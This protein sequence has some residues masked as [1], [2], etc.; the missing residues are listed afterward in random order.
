KLDRRQE[1]TVGENL[2]VLARSAH[3]Y[4]ALDVRVIGRELLIA[5]RPVLLDAFQAALAEVALGEAEAGG[6]PV[7][8]ASAHGPDAVD[9]DVVAVLVADRGHDFGRIKRL[10]RLVPLR[11]VVRPGMEVEVFG[12][13]LSSGFHQGHFGASLRQ[14]F[15][16]HAARGSRAD[17]ANIEQFCA[18]TSQK[19]TT[20]GIARFERMCRTLN[21]AAYMA[22][23]PETANSVLFN[24]LFRPGDNPRSGLWG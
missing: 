18:H 2:Q 13:H 22:A 23:C 7:D 5:D 20:R 1:L 12:G 3:P 8:A 6:V 17:H 19:F 15:R 21:V 9:G 11:E 24:C 14:F 16:E 4:H 10:A